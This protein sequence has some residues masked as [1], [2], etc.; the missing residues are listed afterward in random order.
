MTKVANISI[1]PKNLLPFCYLFLNFVK[2]YKVQKRHYARYK[3]HL[4]VFG[5]CRKFNYCSPSGGTS[6][7][8]VT[9]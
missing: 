6:K 4:L 8:I 5:D 2:S 3:R 7:E 1:F 9:S